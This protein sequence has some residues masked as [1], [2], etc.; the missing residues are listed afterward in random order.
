MNQT[1]HL[2]EILPSLRP[3][4]QGQRL[5]LVRHGETEVEPNQIS[6][7]NVPINDNGREQS[8]GS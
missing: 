1:A 7:A 6:R 2:G 4:H 3:N 8:H 5:L